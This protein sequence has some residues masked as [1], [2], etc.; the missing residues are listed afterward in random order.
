MRSSVK[1]SLDEK[2]IDYKFSEKELLELKDD[3]IND[4]FVDYSYKPEYNIDSPMKLTVKI[5]NIKMYKEYD[6]GL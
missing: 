6:R 1:D 3:I 2:F 5:E 4:G